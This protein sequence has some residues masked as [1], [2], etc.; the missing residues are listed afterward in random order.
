MLL[1]DLKWSLSERHNGFEGEKKIVSSYSAPSIE[2]NGLDDKTAAS[3][4][5]QTGCINKSLPSCLSARWELEGAFK[6]LINQRQ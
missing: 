2:R 6:E 3:P 4:I 1:K 5:A